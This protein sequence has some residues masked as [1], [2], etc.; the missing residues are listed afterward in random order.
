[1]NKLQLDVDEQELLA[2]Y[3][4]SDMQPQLTQERADKLATL[5]ANALQNNH[6]L[7]IQLSNQAFTLLQRRALKE[8]LSYQSL[9]SSILHKYLSGSLQDISPAN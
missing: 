6:Q 1:M 8:G 2:S 7:N 9:I 3:E 5:A 4:A